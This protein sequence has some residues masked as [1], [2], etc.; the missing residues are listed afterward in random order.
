MIEAIAKLRGWLDTNNMTNR[1]I[2]DKYEQAV[3][4]AC[5]RHF[6]DL[7]PLREGKGNLYT[8]LFRAVYA[9]IATHWFC[10]PTVSD[11]EFRAYIQGHFQILNEANEQKRTSMAAQRHYWDYKIADGQGNVD[12]RLGIKLQQSGVQVLEAF[13]TAQT[14]IKTKSHGSLVH[15]RVFHDDRTT[16]ARIQEQFDLHNRAAANHFV[17]ELAQSLLSTADTLNQTPQQVNDKT[18]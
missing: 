17:L 11:L 16:L 4:Q 18:D 12:G 13:D 2:N 1:Q 14:K 3:A 8:H 5:E 6:R 15:L 9:T 7:V 10:P